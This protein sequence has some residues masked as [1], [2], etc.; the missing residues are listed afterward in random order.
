M[1]WF[2]DWLIL[3]LFLIL[4]EFFPA[5]TKIWNEDNNNINNNKSNPLVPLHY[6]SLPLTQHPHHRHHPQ[7]QHHF[8][9]REKNTRQ[10]KRIRSNW[11]FEIF[12][13]IRRSNSI[14]S[15][16]MI[17]SYENVWEL[18]SFV[19][20]NKPK[21]ILVTWCWRTKMVRYISKA[22]EAISLAKELIFFIE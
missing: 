12:D 4:I 16:L 9:Y 18:L 3:F 10:S 19:K 14:R 7:L 13:G 17:S 8:L 1:N 15:I 6:H 21:S 5:E 2:I 11:M 20:I 22:I